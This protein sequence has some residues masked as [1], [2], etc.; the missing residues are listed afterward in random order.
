MKIT[1]S[2]IALLLLFSLATYAQSNYSIKGS[3]IDTAEKMP[4][5][6][7]TIMVLNAKDSILCNFTR[8][9]ADGSFAINDLGKGKFILIMSYLG[10]ADYT[11]GFTIGESVQLSHDFGK[12]N[13]ILKARLLQDVIIKGTVTAIKIKGDTT[14]FNAKAY[15][16]QPNDKVEDLIKQFPGIQVDKDGKI[17]ANGQAVTK[18]LV[19]GEEFFGDD[20]TLVTKNIRADMVDKVQLYDKKSDQA[21]FTGIDDGIKTKTLN[22]KLKEDKKNGYF[23]KIDAGIGSDGYYRSQL[24]YNRFTA[25]QKFSVYGT[26]SNTGQ[27]G[28]GFQ[29]N[30]KYGSAS[31]DF[32]DNGFI[33]VSGIGGDVLDSFDG[34]YDGHGYPLARSGG[35]HFDSKLN[36][37]KAS[38]NTNYKIGS[39]DVNGENNTT[40]Q[41]LLPDGYIS[42]RNQ[43]YDNYLFRQKV[44]ITYQTKL[45]TT[46]NLKVSADATDKNIRTISNDLSV[47]QRGNGVL[48]N[49]NDGHQNSD[50]WQKLFNASAFY[51]KKFKKAGR[52]LSFLVNEA[53]SNIRSTGSLYSK[54]AYYDQAGLLDSTR[55]TDQY[56]VNKSESESINTNLTYTEPFSKIFALSIN[57][58]VSV[59]N[60]TSDKKAYSQANQGSGVY[61]VLVDSVSSNFRFN[62]LANQAG[63]NFNYN[64]GKTLITFGTKAAAVNF[65]ETVYDNTNGT[66]KNNYNRNFI[67]LT[68]QFTYLYK[69]SQQRSF[70]FRYSGSTTQPNIDQLQPVRVNTD[71]LNITIGNPNLKPTFTNGVNMTYNSFKQLSGQ[72]FYITG[73]YGSTSNPFVNY[74][75]LDSAGKSTNQTIN[76]NGK[77]TYS[78]NFYT[79][80]SW[81]INPIDL[82]LGF[83]IE[84]NANNAYSYINGQLNT[85]DAGRYSVGLNISKY[86][87]KKY[88]FNF[89]LAPNYSIKTSSIRPDLN[90]NGWGLNS[91]ASGNVFL[92]GKFQVGSDINY[93]FLGKTQAQNEE[94]KRTIWNASL[95][96]TF[97][98]EDKLKLSF[99]VNDLLNQN[100]GFSRSISGSYLTENSYT[101]IKRYFMVALAYDFTKFGTIK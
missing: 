37:D 75:T 95:S 23:G 82:Q 8:A 69:F 66:V 87:Q 65:K 46:S 1:I 72:Y 18:V 22:I 64:K 62:Q 81:K 77:K 12:I 42:T 98:K 85:S 94:L 32:S 83:F 57:Y 6:N 100:V 25:K 20:P 49:T 7:A 96:R 88:S 48:L 2:L 36:N 40:R 55:L 79:T 63:V 34:Q 29:D 61:N 38:I 45:D 52:T 93:M 13:M 92:P 39:M 60:S 67:N 21:T 68:P 44:D 3:A 24:I 43:N 14:E 4:L 73:G 90:A 33:S 50:G 11:E 59:N 41:S 15:V 5:S 47:T 10:Y 71:P 70:T 86:E 51:T 27:V 58:G 76:L 84:V 78:Y 26:N 99:T 101:T 28:L 54:I 30:S 74:S 97:L 19:D 80:T 91:N 35:V 17:T 53:Y 31:L 89:N 56:K 9:T 16:I